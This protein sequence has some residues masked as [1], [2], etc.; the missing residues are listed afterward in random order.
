MKTRAGALLESIE[1][2]TAVSILIYID[3]FLFTIVHV[4]SL[5][6]SK[7]TVNDSPI[8]MKV[9]LAILQFNQVAFIIEIT[10]AIYSFGMS[11]FYH[12]GYTLDLAIISAIVFSSN[13]VIPLG[14]RFLRFWRFWRLLTTT[15]LK[16]QT[17]T[18]KNLLECQEQM[19]VASMEVKRLD[20]TC[21]KEISL[22]EEI[23]KHLIAYKDEIDTLKEALQI[24]AMDIVGIGKQTF[25]DDNLRMASTVED[26][27]FFDS[28]EGTQVMKQIPEG[29]L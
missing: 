28:N 24:A 19:Q 3:V 6:A 15:Q 18:A 5:A 29:Q 17:L 2:Q 7:S 10:G 23:E 26:I 11:F 16:A 25:G 12:V 13:N 22:R 27:A 8:L 14:L 20:A 1:T 9:V 21:R 4:V